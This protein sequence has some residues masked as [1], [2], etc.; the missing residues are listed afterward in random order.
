[1][2]TIYRQFIRCSGIYDFI[3][4]TLHHCST[5]TLIF[6]NPPNFSSHSYIRLMLRSNLHLELWTILTIHSMI[7]RVP[8]SFRDGIAARTRITNNRKET[9][10]EQIKP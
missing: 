5:T 9:D 1:M 7:R 8:V 6:R 3:I 4:T 2:Q 10:D